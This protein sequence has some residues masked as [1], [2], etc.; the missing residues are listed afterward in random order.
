M[1]TTSSFTVAGRV[2]F[3]D[4]ACPVE[5]VQFYLDD[6]TREAAH[7]EYLESIEPY[8]RESGYQIPGEFVVVR[9]TKR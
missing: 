2:L 6:A 3:E 1:V 7:A 8:R 9:G 5:D 4:T